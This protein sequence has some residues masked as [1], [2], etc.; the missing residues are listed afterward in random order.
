MQITYHKNLTVDKWS[1]LSLT[2]Q[3]ANIGAEIKRALF[4]QERKKPN[5]AKSALYRALELFDLT[6]ASLKSYP[7]LKEVARTR[8]VVVDYFVGDNQY[9]STPN[10]LNRYFYHF[11]LLVN[12]RKYETNK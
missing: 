3:L 4:W 7:A 2:E 11:N 6:L 1:S 5:L 8:E 12:Y 10:N 9:Q